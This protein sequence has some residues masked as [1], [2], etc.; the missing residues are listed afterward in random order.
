[1][2]REEE[3]TKTVA[4]IREIGATAELELPKSA[5]GCKELRNGDT[6]RNNGGGGC[7]ETLH[8]PMKKVRHVI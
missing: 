8:H 6:T 3:R 7:V 2:R 4:D 5:K 1:M